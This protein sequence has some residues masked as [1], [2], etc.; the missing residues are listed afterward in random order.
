MPKVTINVLN[1]ILAALFI[2]ILGITSG[3]V[4]RHPE[5]KYK[6]HTV[7][8]TKPIYLPGKIIYVHD[9]DQSAG[10]DKPFNGQYPYGLYFEKHIDIAHP[11]IITGKGIDITTHVQILDASGDATAYWQIRKDISVNCPDTKLWIAKVMYDPFTQNY[12]GGIYRNQLFGPMGI[13]TG[14]IAD[15]KIIEAG[16]AF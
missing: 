1:L 9:K 4:M 11:P 13:G 6:D 12:G 10:R 8:I 16:W 14:I 15:K 5:T 3:W 2:L 7:E